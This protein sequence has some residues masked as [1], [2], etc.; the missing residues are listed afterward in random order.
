MRLAAVILAAGKGTRML[1][2]L[3]KAMHTLC[4]EPM[5]GFLLERAEDAGAS[6]TAVIAGHGIERV[7]EYVG[8]RAV[9]VAQNKQWGSGHAV[10]QAERALANFHGSVFV[11]YCDTPLIRRSTVESLLENH[12]QNKTVCT[13]LSVMRQDPQG[14]GRVK[15]GT[16]GRVEKI[17]EELDAT[18]GEKRIREVNV[19]CY[20]FDKKKLFH[21]LKGITKNPKKKEVYLTDVIEV[22]ARDG[23]V[24]SVAVGD[25][26]E[27]AGINTR[28]DLAEMEQRMQKEILEGWLDRGVTIRDPKTTVIDADVRIGQDTVLLPH[29]CLEEGTVIGKGCRIGPFARVRGKSQIGDGAIIG[30]FVEIVRSRVG[31]N[32]Q[33]KHLSYIGDA[34]IGASVNIGAGTITANYDGRKKHKTVIGDKAQ[35]GSGTILIAPVRIGSGAKTGAGAVVPKGKNVP[36]GSVVIGIPA[37]TLARGK[38]R[39]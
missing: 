8:D 35:I 31:K 13:L 37:R 22:L 27:V 7:R 20:I 11:F 38:R 19:G 33:I 9:I 24:E 25:E 1:S 21:A 16:G 30:N 18:P 17:V 36:A 5:L 29:T 10:S 39:G 23:R 3:P 32:T 26:G 12:R 28:R 6:K 4:G 14:Y 2:E 15:R 34:E